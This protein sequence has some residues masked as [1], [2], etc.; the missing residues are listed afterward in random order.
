MTIRGSRRPHVV[1]I[2]APS[3]PTPP[4]PHIYRKIAYT[5]AAFT[6]LIILAVLWL[7]SV[8]AEILVRV[9]R[10]PLKLDT[11]VEIAKTPASGQL[12][13][14]IV[15]GT[16]DS[17][18]HE[19]TVTDTASSTA[20]TEPT[21]GTPVPA[22][23]PT[24]ESEVDNA[25][26]VAKGTVRLI[27]K[28]SRPQ[29]LVKTTRLLTADN[30]L[31]R[32]DKTVVVPS[33]GEVAV[34]VY[35]DKPGREFAI[36]PTKFTIPG[37]F[38]DLQTFIYAQSD[39][40]FEA[41]PAGAPVPVATVPVSASAPLVDA[42]PKKIVTAN[43]IAD[44]QKSLVD[45]A[46]EQAKRTLAAEMADT[47]YNEVVYATRILDQKI[48]VKAGQAADSFLASLKL[49]VTAVYYPTDDMSALI[50]LRMKEKIPEGRELLPFDDKSAKYEIE[51]SDIK[52]EKA[53]IHVLVDA[54]HRLTS[55]NP[56]LQKAAVAGR[57]KDEVISTL[58]QLEGVE[59]VQIKMRPSW[60]SK[61][62]TLKDHIE[63]KVE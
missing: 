38:I 63:I 13:G 54:E 6:V 28:Y 52:N 20:P 9:K 19:F 3:F 33:G 11:T 61:I 27:N 31:Y 25:S 41:V 8:R 57:K 23:L 37:L 46:F 2:T 10:S 40:A 45:A 36:G 62:P 21:A 39:T 16:F 49:E 12:P 43:A 55:T 22:S 50:R 7:T 24:P 51:S 42:K 56:A 15:Q 47:R 5:F 14:R 30:K 1:P 44:A 35:A 4:Q 17:S 32:I 48:N 29:T 34:G 60:I 58:K 18:V 26:F 59:D 53:L